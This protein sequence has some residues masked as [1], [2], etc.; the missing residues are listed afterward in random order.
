M[1]LAKMVLFIL[2]GCLLVIG[3]NSVAKGNTKGYIGLTVGLLGIFTAIVLYFYRMQ[4][5]FT[6]SESFSTCLNTM[7]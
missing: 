2:A 4:Q 7:S 6:F 1:G 3:A 5:M